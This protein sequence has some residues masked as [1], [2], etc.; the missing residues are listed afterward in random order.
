MN[1]QEK[2][3]DVLERALDAAHQEMERLANMA[4]AIECKYRDRIVFLT[5]LVEQQREL[6]ETLMGRAISED[7]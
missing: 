3:I 7:E 6:I 1:E 4:T 2:T 5:R